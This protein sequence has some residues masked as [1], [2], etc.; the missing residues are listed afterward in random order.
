MTLGCKLPDDFKALLI[1]KYRSTDLQ[2]DALFQMQVALG[3]SPQR[4]KEGEPYNFEPIRVQEMADINDPNNSDLL[5]PGGK[6]FQMMNV[7][8]P[9]GFLRNPNQAPP[10][11]FPIDVCGGC[12]AK[13]RGDGN[14]L[15]Q[16]GKCK[17]KKY[18]G[19]VC[20]QAHFKRHKPFCKE[21]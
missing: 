8:A 2:R 14:P 6:S 5:F 7:A 13:E 21:Q 15:L 16:C 17:T 20:Q 4:Y 19:K 12:G 3:D 18:C 9:F 10:K 1:K 11:E